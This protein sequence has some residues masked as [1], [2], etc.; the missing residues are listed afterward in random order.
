M[1]RLRRGSR[2]EVLSA[3]QL[4]LKMCTPT[5]PDWK[6]GFDDSYRF[7]T[8]VPLDTLNDIRSGGGL[9]T[10]VSALPRCAE[11]PDVEI[12]VQASYAIHDRTTH[13]SL[14]PS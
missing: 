9:Q 11:W 5:I 2:S 14:L 7:T 12:Q 6:I 1:Y 4:L 13:Q 8:N 10:L 3:V